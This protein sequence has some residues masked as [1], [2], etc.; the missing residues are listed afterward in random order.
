MYTVLGCRKCL[1]KQYSVQKICRQCTSNII[2]NC[3]NTQTLK[4]KPKE[5]DEELHTNLRFC[6]HLQDTEWHIIHMI[7]K[8]SLGK[9]SRYHFGSQHIPSTHHLFIMTLYVPNKETG[10]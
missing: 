8:Q 1:V 10:I 4:V 6:I 3:T 7:V 5:R 2:H 9:I